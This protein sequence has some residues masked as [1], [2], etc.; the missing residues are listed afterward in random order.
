MDKRTLSNYGWIVVLT[1]VLS[2]MIALATP[3]GEYVKVATTNALDGFI[4][5]A[6]QAIGEDNISFNGDKWDSK[7]DYGKFDKINIIDTTEKNQEKI[8]DA[9]NEMKENTV[10]V[11]YGVF[12]SNT[13]YQPDTYE[14]VEYIET[15][16][17]EKELIQT[18]AFV[19]FNKK[20]SMKLSDVTEEVFQYSANYFI[21]YISESKNSE[22]MQIQGLY[23]TNSEENTLDNLIY[24]V[25]F[26]RNRWNEN[27]SVAKYNENKKC[28]E[29]Y[30]CETEIESITEFYD[31]VEEVKT[32]EVKVSSAKFNSE[33]V[34]IPTGNI[35]IEKGM[36][37]EQWTNSEYNT[38]GYISAIRTSDYEVVPLTDVIDE[39][40]SYAFFEKEISG[41]W[42]FNDIVDLY[43]IV[44]EM[45]LEV[46]FKS[47]NTKFNGFMINQNAIGYGIPFARTYYTTSDNWTSEEYK[48]VDFGM[49][50]QNVTKQF[51]DWFIK[52]ATYQG[53]STD[54]G[55]EDTGCFVEG[56]LITLSNGI[57]KPIEQITAEDELLVWNFHTGTSDTALP[58]I[59]ESGNKKAPVIELIFSDGTSVK[60][61]DEHGFF[62]KDLNKFVYITENNIKNHIGYNFIKLDGNNYKTVKLVDYTI[63]TKNIKYYTIQTAIH[64]NCI[65]EN[66]LT[67]T[68]PASIVDDR[69]FDYFEIGD[70]M[71]YDVQ[72]KQ[73]DIEKY[74]LYEYKD[75]AQYVTYEQ[76]IAFNGPYL[77]ILVE[78]NIITYEQ[79]L[80]VIGMY[81]DM[82]VA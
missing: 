29:H 70:N 9:L 6:D 36:T 21:Y 11:S 54:E 41:V 25:A 34:F 22:K 3:F 62:N 74:G 53:E 8:E 80:D 58:S 59:I 66:M 30:D 7:F 45:G 51:Y 38:L 47:G 2:V 82:I 17:V 43:S 32:K 76:F 81:A 13:T 73:A 69:W 26:M 31:V 44:E 46:N 20:E 4:E 15:T 65:A 5:V 56:T 39:N 35:T 52:N 50:I 48:T 33:L 12:D 49:S 60:I 42:K 68:P 78:K 77:K 57:Q 75:F 23:A 28:Y 10:N 64:N 61:V 79:I 18:N 72:K 67:Q 55:I 40:K 19:I 37:W 63:T 71:K 24:A 1:L 16:L 14:T 27:W